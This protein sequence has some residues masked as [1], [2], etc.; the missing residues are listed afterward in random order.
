MITGKAM[1]IFYKNTLT[2]TWFRFSFNKISDLLSG[3]NYRNLSLIN[4]DFE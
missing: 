2:K 1:F 4:I 3:L